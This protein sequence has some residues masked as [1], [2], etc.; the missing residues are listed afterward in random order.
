MLRTEASPDAEDRCGNTCGGAGL[1]LGKVSHAERVRM[2]ELLGKIYCPNCG[3]CASEHR[4]H[5]AAIGHVAQVGCE[6]TVSDLVAY[7][8]DET[9]WRMQQ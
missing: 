9:N 1:H 2:S 5:V 8:D 4:G 6:W 7:H 3:V